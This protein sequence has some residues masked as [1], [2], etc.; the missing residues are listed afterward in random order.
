LTGHFSSGG[1]ND[2]LNV[3][4]QI[5]LAV[6]TRYDMGMSIYDIR[7]KALGAACLIFVAVVGGS[8]LK[9]KK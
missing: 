9:R 6:I 4:Q 3:F 5:M 1:C 2:R 7:I 8:L